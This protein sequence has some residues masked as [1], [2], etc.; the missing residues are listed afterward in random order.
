M[1]AFF[2][3]LLIFGAANIV[4]WLVM[5]QIV[6]RVSEDKGDQRRYDEAMSNL[7]PAGGRQARLRELGD[8]ALQSARMGKLEQAEKLGQELEVSSPTNGDDIEKLHTALGLVALK[9]GDIATAKERLLASGRAPETPVRSSFGP[10]M[11]LAKA[12]LEAGEKDTVLQHFGLCRTFWS[13]RANKLDEWTRDVKLGIPP[14]F[15]M[16]LK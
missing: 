14:D 5:F 16:N 2:R 4:L 9:R 15:A 6:P 1:K 13:F 11:V 8:A 10:T 7:Q 3:Y 12:L